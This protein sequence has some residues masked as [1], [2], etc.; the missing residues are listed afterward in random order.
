MIT[1]ANT[2]EIFDLFYYENSRKQTSNES[3]YFTNLCQLID[4]NSI[5][6]YRILNSPQLNV[7][8]I[9]LVE[10]GN[11]NQR[12]DYLENFTEFLDVCIYN[13]ITPINLEFTPRI[14]HPL[15]RRK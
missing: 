6:C 13:F 7:M 3:L 5:P 8:A 11:E 1:D 4:G 14:L 15:E 10:F 9:H 12:K 2:K